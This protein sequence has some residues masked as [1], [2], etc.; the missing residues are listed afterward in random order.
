MQ[1]LVTPGELNLAR[2]SARLDSA[3]AE[4]AWITECV[5]SGFNTPQLA[6]V[7]YQKPALIYGRRGGDENSIGARAA[8]VGYELLRRRSGG[9]VV[10]AG[11][12]MLGLDLLLPAE[13]WLSR[14]GPFESFRWV[15]NCWRKALAQ[16]NSYPLM[17]DGGSIAAHNAAAK[18]AGLDWVCFAGMSHGELLDGQGRK[19]LGLAQARGRWGILLSAGLLV[20]QT[21]WENLEYIHLGLRP[22]LSAMHQQASVG[23]AS[24]VPKLNQENLIRSVLHY[25]QCE[26]LT[27][28]R[29]LYT[30]P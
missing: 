19:L 27:A 7:R 9:G 14:V 1:R 11:P 21:P 5:E 17:A 28:R 22:E 10:L 18:S 8:E 20:E 6:V 25:L 26:L 24:L 2:H 23:L 12:W 16:F 4:Q 29:P 13:H 3:P 30:G 15:G